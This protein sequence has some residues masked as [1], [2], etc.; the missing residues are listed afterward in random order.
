M[1]FFT[2]LNPVLILFIFIVI[3]FIV[4]KINVVD[5][6]F[7]SSFSKFIFNVILPSMIIYSMNFPFDWE[8]LFDSG[9]LL[10]ISVFVLMI[11][12]CIALMIVKLLKADRKERSVYYYSLLFSNFTFMGFPVISAVYGKE[13]LFYASIFVIPLRIAYNTLGVMLFKRGDEKSIKISF[14]NI[15]NPPLIAVIIGLCIFVFSIKFPVPIET[16]LGMLTDMLMPLGMMLAGMMLG[17]GKIG[18][19][20]GNIKIYIV[21]FARLVIVPVSIYAILVY[22]GFN[23]YLLGIPVIISAMPVAATVGIIAERYNGKSYLGAQCTFVSTA[24]SIITIPLITFFLTTYFMA[25]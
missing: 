4:R 5:E 9:I 17:N 15:I 22:F 6:I 14:R 13:G 10:I 8:I 2:T 24:F 12:G 1:S 16:V 25:K 23:S 3:G 7:V 21:A 18:D 20:G 19:L 11:S